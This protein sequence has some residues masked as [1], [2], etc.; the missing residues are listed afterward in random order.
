[1]T[2]DQ[3]MINFMLHKK[4]EIDQIRI[5]LATALN[6]YKGSNFDQLYDKTEGILTQQLRSKVSDQNF[7]K[8]KFSIDYCLS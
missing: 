7:L 6:Y 4:V 8:S 3:T 2:K 1:M 5:F